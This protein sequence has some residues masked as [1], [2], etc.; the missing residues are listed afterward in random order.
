[1]LNLLSETGPWSDQVLRRLSLKHNP[2]LGI[3]TGVHRRFHVFTMACPFDE[4]P[5]DIGAQINPPGAINKT[6]AR[7]L[8][9]SDDFLLERY[10]FPGKSLIY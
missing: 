3:P 1:M 10:R 8:G 2:V 5:A 7:H 4:R 9:I 6:T